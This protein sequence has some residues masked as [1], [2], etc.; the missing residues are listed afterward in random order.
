MAN[1]NA[2]AGEIPNVVYVNKKWIPNV[3]FIVWYANFL[4][5]SAYHAAGKEFQ[6]FYICFHGSSGIGKTAIFKSFM[7]YHTAMMEKV[8]L[9]EF[10]KGGIRKLNLASTAGEDLEI[11]VANHTTGT[12]EKISTLKFGKSPCIIQLDELNRY[13]S[14]DTVNAVTRIIMDR[15]GTEVPPAGSLV[16]CA[17]NSS[18]YAGTKEFPEH[19]ITRGVHIYL[20]EKS[21]DAVKGNVEY[22]RNE[23]YPDWMIEAFEMSPTVSQDDFMEIATYQPR[24]LEYFRY[25][26]EAVEK[27]EITYGIKTPDFLLRAMGAGAIGSNMSAQYLKLRAM[28]KLPSLSQVLNDPENALIPDVNMDMAL[29]KKYL[30]RLIE[31]VS[32]VSNVTVSAGKLVRYIA[33]YSDEFG[34][35]SMEKLAKTVPSVT[36]SKEYKEWIARIPVESVKGNSMSAGI[37]NAKE[38]SGKMWEITL[39]TGD[40]A[41][42]PD[43]RMRTFR[44]SNG[45]TAIPTRCTYSI[46]AKGEINIQS[47]S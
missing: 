39:D 28:Q 3:M 45:A 2:G 13:Q 11:P 12:V 42:T 32:T 44:D 36:T 7:K 15:D 8:G 16:A 46:G 25:I 19:L 34:R 31:E 20:S 27:A 22:M 1:M 26:A 40:I 35:D 33:R 37:V 38:S 6:N 24:T 29:R 30:F 9:G 4:M 5:Q 47:F 23:G 14:L 21:T 41:V 18:S 10:F 43:Y 17:A